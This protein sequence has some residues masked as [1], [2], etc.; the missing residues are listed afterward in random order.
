MDTPSDQ[1]LP[2]A[3]SRPGRSEPPEQDLGL[4]IDREGTWYYRGS[5]IRRQP[6]VKLFATVLR[7]GSDGSYWMVTPVE[8][9]RVEV[10]DVPFVAVELRAEGQ[11]AARRLRLRSNLDEW[12]T[13]GPEHPL[14]LHA[15]A[16]AKPNEP[17]SVPVP[18]VEVRP[19][20]VARL[21][22]PVYYELAEL[23]EAHEMNG[24]AAFGVWSSGR[25]FPLED[26][27]S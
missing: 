14:R 26:V 1:D 5:A 23:G 21:A 12:V 6:L 13:V 10:E 27:G 15:P 17:E 9:G 4:R 24:R 11:G 20:L 25:F 2:T 19:G 8:R 3:S 22:R 7:R 16:W 18:Y